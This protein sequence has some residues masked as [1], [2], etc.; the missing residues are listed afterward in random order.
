M[1]E[2]CKNSKIKSIVTDYM[3]RL[4]SWINYWSVRQDFWVHFFNNLSLTRDD[5]KRIKPY[6]EITQKELMLIWRT[7]KE[8]LPV[9]SY[10]AKRPKSVY[11]FVNNNKNFK[12][13]L[14]CFYLNYMG[15]IWPKNHL[16]R[17]PFK[18]KKRW[19]AFANSDVS[20][21][22]NCKLGKK[23]FWSR[24]DWHC[25][26][27]WLSTYMEFFAKHFL[28]FYICPD[29]PLDLFSLNL[30]GGL[31]PFITITNYAFWANRRI[32]V[33]EILI[34]YC[35]YCM[36]TIYVQ[37]TPVFGTVL[38][39]N[40]CKEPIPKIWNKY[41]QKKNC[42]SPNFHIHFFMQNNLHRYYSLRYSAQ[43]TLLQFTILC[44]K[45]SKHPKK[46]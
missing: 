4:F 27:S 18:C 34:G 24:F 37:Q 22:R 11:I 41:S 6:T 23:I 40:H 35:M 44:I 8:P 30:R 17:C 5:A 3:W 16:T 20:R 36:S 13:F 21:T 15:W 12:Q 14:D 38:R 42:H 2:K 46:V 39:S 43:R 28:C 19:T 31:V 25:H 26:F 29:C 10:Y 45:S 32:P 33:F 1:L 9:F 7:R